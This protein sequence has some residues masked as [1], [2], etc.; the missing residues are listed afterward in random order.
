MTLQIKIHTP[1]TPSPGQAIQPLTGGAALVGVEAEP[2][3]RHGRQVF[4]KPRPGLTP[5]PA[6][7][8]MLLVAPPLDD[9]P[10]LVDQF[11]Q[12]LASGDDKKPRPKAPEWCRSFYRPR[13]LTDLGVQ[14]M[15]DLD[16][17]GAGK[18]FPLGYGDP[19][20]TLQDRL[21]YLARRHTALDLVKKGRAFSVGGYY[22]HISRVGEGVKLLKDWWKE[23]PSGG[24]PLDHEELLQ[25]LAIYRR[26]SIEQILAL[27]PGAMRET[28]EDLD[29]LTRDKCLEVQ[30]VQLGLGT[31]ETVAL[32]EKGWAHVRAKHPEAKA[33]GWGPR[34]PLPQNR[35]FHE[36]VVGDA[37][38]Y[39]LHE[40]K[41]YEAEPFSVLL[42]PALRR[43]YLG[44]PFIP[45]LRLDYTSQMGVNAHY[46]MEVEG[47]GDDYR[48]HHHREKLSSG[49]EFRVFGTHG[50]AS[51]GGGG[52]FVRR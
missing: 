8:H 45:D 6:P 51:A 40:L 12:S 20:R 52:I 38:T 9:P 10:R 37:V 1:A 24:A 34:R 4:G 49:G 28:W 31:I 26:P 22:H 50:S 29:R 11:G 42:D 25:W 46:L 16:P 44:A 14:I 7:D 47:G 23:M 5:E 21:D 33:S 39:A 2:R 30:S 18:A 35:E 17:R 32:T 36:Q 19:N 41:G 48:G 43:L 27:A 3:W 15:R 13:G